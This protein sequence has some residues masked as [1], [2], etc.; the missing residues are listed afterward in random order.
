MAK[1]PPKAAER[2][3]FLRPRH[4]GYF[5]RV[6]LAE[7]LGTK[8]SRKDV[9]LSA[10]CSHQKSEMQTSFFIFLRFL[11]NHLPNVGR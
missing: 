6:H 11:L 3:T 2:E 5:S 7:K 4:N 10:R 8:H 1:F 9:A